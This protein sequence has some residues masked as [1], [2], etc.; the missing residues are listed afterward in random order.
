MQHSILLEESDYQR[1]RQEALRLELTPEALAQRW[2]RER[3]E[4]TAA[5]AN[6]NPAQALQ[7]TSVSEVLAAAA[8]LSKARTNGDEALRLLLEA[9]FTAP[10]GARQ[11]IEYEIRAFLQRYP[12][13]PDD[14]RKVL[15]H[16]TYPIAPL[17]AHELSQVLQ[18]HPAPLTL[19]LEELVARFGPAPVQ[20]DIQAVL[21]FLRWKKTE[22]SSMLVAEALGELATRA[23]S[24]MFRSAI[25]LLRRQWGQPFPPAAFTRALKAIE[26]ATLAWKDLPLPAAEQE[27]EAETHDLPIPAPEKS[28]E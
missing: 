2:L 17:V 27:Q 10:P 24:P 28:T 9:R 14:V 16:C 5:A 12:L 3:L 15:D 18:L 4:L 19:T 7:S 23:P 8:A 20:A 22:V 25:P 21:L 6:R 1:L 13:L 26:K 11:G